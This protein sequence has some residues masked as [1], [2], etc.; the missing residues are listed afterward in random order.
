LWLQV[1]HFYIECA[2]SLLLYFLHF[3][4][5]QPDFTLL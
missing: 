3:C 4:L 1:A 2:V 5:S